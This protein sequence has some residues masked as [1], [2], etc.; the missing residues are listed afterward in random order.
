MSKGKDASGTKEPVGRIFFLDGEQLRYEEVE[1]GSP[2]EHAGWALPDGHP[3]VSEEES[4]MAY[5]LAEGIRG[6]L[7]PGS[8]ERL[9]ALLREDARFFGDAA[10]Y[11]MLHLVDEYENR[12]RRGMEA[13][14]MTR[15]HEDLNRT[16]HIHVERDGDGRI[17]SVSVDVSEERGTRALATLERAI[18][19]FFSASDGYGA[20]GD[21]VWLAVSESL[22]THLLLWKVQ[23]TLRAFGEDA[24]RAM[25][26]EAF[27]EEAYGRLGDRNLYAQLRD[28]EAGHYRAVAQVHAHH[29]AL[30]LDLQR[31]SSRQIE[32]AIGVALEGRDDLAPPAQAPPEDRDGNY[33]A[34]NAHHTYLTTRALGRGMKV[35]ERDPDGNPYPIHRFKGGKGHAELRPPEHDDGFLSAEQQAFLGERMWQHCANLGNLDADLFDALSILWLDRRSRHDGKATAHVDD[36][37]DMRGLTQKINGKGVRGGYYASQRRDISQALDRMESLWVSIGQV[38]FNDDKR[39]KYVEET[40]QDRAYHFGPRTVQMCLDGSV[41]WSRFSFYPGDVFRHF[42]AGKGRQVQLLSKKILEYKLD[43]NPHEKHLGRYLSW[44]WRTDGKDYGR[45]HLIETLLEEANFRFDRRNPKR[46]R[47]NLHGCLKR[48][49]DDGVVRA[50]D[51]AEPGK[52]PKPEDG[53]GWGRRWLGTRVLVEPPE[54][55]KDYCVN[56]GRA[57]EKYLPK[58]SSEQQKRYEFGDDLKRA[59]KERGRSQIQLAEDLDTTQGTISKIEAGKTSGPPELRKRIRKWLDTG[60]TFSKVTDD[61]DKYVF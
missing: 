31:L 36:I 4:R 58:P 13:Q 42:L 18:E 57:R 16:G 22:W 59:R 5:A 44:K 47:D 43:E 45:P 51:Y 48:L 24:V 40:L 41:E 32:V 49:K 2:E 46:S 9:A 38:G 15:L 23:D 37:L 11:M 3:G 54:A 56:A 21:G 25:G 29:Y 20:P 50:W 27:V 35:W 6:S 60:E 61:L 14:G 8:V 52:E 26:S 34:H 39:K 53:K 1:F 28:H 19:D 30:A 7:E 12:L 33:E 17:K 55:V 10:V